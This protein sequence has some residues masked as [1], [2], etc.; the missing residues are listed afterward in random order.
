M[1]YLSIKWYGEDDSRAFYF[2]S[3]NSLINPLLF[4]TLNTTL[5]RKAKAFFTGIADVCLCRGKTGCKSGKTTADPESPV[6]D[7]EPTYFKVDDD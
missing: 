1:I 3:T 2:G 7:L 6:R 4:I 5:R